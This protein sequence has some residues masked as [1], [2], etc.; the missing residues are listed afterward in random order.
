MENRDNQ[1]SS[2]GILDRLRAATPDVIRNNAPRVVALL[3]ICGS[4]S[5]L[6][7]KNRLFSVAGAGFIAANSIIGIFGTKKSEEQK[8]RLRQEEESKKMPAGGVAEYAFKALHPGKYPLESGATLAS[9]SSVLWTAAGV[10]GNKGELSYGRL[11]GGGLSL[12]A[13]ANIALTKER[14]AD[15]KANTHP[16][17]SAGYYLTELKHRPVLVSSLLNVACD[18]ASIVGGLH[19]YRKGKEI[20]TLVAGAFLMSANL[21]Q[22]AYVNKNDYNIEPSASLNEAAAG[23]APPAATNHATAERGA[24]AA[25][26]QQKIQQ[27]PAAQAAIG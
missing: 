3:K 10:Y 8:E 4:S 23:A 26:W 2:T 22:A 25:S 6:L 12:A 9:A 7:S 16:K 17:G 27:A 11:L 21:F 18:A 13:D 14:F 1:T 24:K 20:N 5:M 15:V 19:E